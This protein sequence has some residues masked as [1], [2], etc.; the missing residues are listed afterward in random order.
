M[1]VCVCVCVCECVCVCVCFKLYGECDELRL[2]L[3]VGNLFMSSQSLY[4]FNL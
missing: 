3:L 1:C 2:T 4:S